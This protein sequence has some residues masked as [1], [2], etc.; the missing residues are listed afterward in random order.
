[1]NC[2]ATSRVPLPGHRAA[3]RGRFHLADTGSIFLD[4]IGEMALMTQAKILRAIQE[5][6][7]EPVGSSETLKV[8]TRVIAATHKNLE[9]EVRNGGFREDLYYRLNVVS[10]HIPPLRET[11]GGCPVTGGIFSRQI[12]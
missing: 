6:A 10:V 5:Q 7:F 1:M 4:E 12:Q 9:E 3:A 8:D 2:S 11:K